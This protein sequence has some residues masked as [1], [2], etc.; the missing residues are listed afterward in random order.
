MLAI[1]CV[2]VVFS[3]STA[4][5]DYTPVSTTLTLPAFA[6]SGTLSCITLNILD[7]EEMEEREYFSLRLEN[8]SPD[9]VTVNEG[10]DILRVLILDDDCESMACLK[11][12]SNTYY[13]IISI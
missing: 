5:A 9:I 6:P 12:T 2:T 11:W 8:L 1:I 4:G 13:A 3:Q 7:D 10:G